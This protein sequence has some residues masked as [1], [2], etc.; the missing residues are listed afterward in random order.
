VGI[1]IGAG[2]DFYRIDW[3]EMA[4]LLP[5]LIILAVTSSL[6]PAIRASKLDV[7]KALQYE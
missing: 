1:Q 5:A 2:P 3:G 4:I 7:V 6:L